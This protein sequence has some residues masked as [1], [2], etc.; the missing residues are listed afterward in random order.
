MKNRK[1]INGIW[2]IISFIIPDKILDY[3]EGDSVSYILD[4]HDKIT[5]N[6]KN[7]I[8][9]NHNREYSDFIPL[10]ERIKNKRYNPIMVSQLMFEDVFVFNT[11]EEAKNAY[12][13]FEI[14]NIGENR[15]CAW[16]YGKDDFFDEINR[17]EKELNTKVLYYNVD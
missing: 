16:W 8:E 11:P 14:G 4:T 9:Y 2:S 10:I 17:Y 5:I 12:Q 1:I 13:E 7:D 15:I 3:L 6:K